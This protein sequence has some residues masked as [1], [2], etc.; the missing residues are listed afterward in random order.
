[1]TVRTPTEGSG[2]VQRKLRQ[3]A[4]LPVAELDRVGTKAERELAAL[5]IETVLDVFT[6]YPR[7][8]IDGTRLR[9]IT[10]LQAGEK[11]SVLARV[12]RVRPAS[13]GY[14]RGR[15]RGPSRVEVEIADDSGR[16]RVVFFNQTWRAKQLPVGT[17]AL[18]F[19]SIVDLPGRPPAH[20][21]HDRGAGGGRSG[22][23]TGTGTGDGDEP[24]G[25][26]DRG[27]IY[28]IYPLS[29]K[30]KLTS[31]AHRPDRRRGA[32][33]GQDF[34]DP[35]AAGVA[36]PVRRWSIAPPPSTTSTGPPRWKR[37]HRP[38]AVW[39]STSCSGS[40]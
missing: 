13:S 18:F 20:Q 40:S 3:L 16:L 8:Y 10:E 25:R 35:V 14:G 7:R 21:S 33:P 30:A 6:H 27:R 23:A 28:P 19:G 1:M 29:D 12:T 24:D 17:L 39:P 37:R 34:A 22:A 15:R 9:P 32:G 26:P 11:V 38:A 4:E 31:T 5:G 36:G 2:A